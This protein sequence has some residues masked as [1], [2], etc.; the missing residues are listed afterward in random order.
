M[1]VRCLGSRTPSRAVQ[2]AKTST[3]YACFG[4]EGLKSLL[5][6]LLHHGGSSILS[7]TEKRL[8]EFGCFLRGVPRNVDG[9][10]LLKDG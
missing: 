10:A 4:C 1:V 8:K 7:Y 9:Q 5:H 3:Q 6:R 2:L